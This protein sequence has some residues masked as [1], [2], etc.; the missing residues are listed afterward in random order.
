[1]ARISQPW[2]F[3]WKEIDEASDLDRLRLVL[4]ALPDEELVSLLEQRRGRGRDD[5][6]IR[7]MWNA[8]I[9][10]VVFQHST[11]AALIRE[12]WRNGE[13]RQLCGFNPFGGM[14][15]APSDDAMERFLKLVVE[16]REIP[17]PTGATKPTKEQEKMEPPGRR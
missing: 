12:L 7:P 2:L 16:H 9:A 15:S 1:M 14:A 3:T 10:G 6:P 17:M 11:A 8:V 13:L 5:Y 4:D